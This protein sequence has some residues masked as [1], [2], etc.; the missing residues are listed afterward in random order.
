MRVL[1]WVIRPYL[2]IRYTF[3]RLTKTGGFDSGAVYMTKPF[4][5]SGNLLKDDLHRF[6]VKQF[7]ESSCSVASLAS[8]VNTLMHQQGGVAEPPVSQQDLLDRVKT[9][10]WKERMSDT[11]YKGRRGLPLDILGQVVQSCLDAYQLSY[12]S[13]ETVQVTRS[14][15]QIKACK[16]TLLK[17]LLAFEQQGNC[18]IIAHFDQGSFLPEY[19]IPHISPVGGF[20]P[21]TWAV[22]ILDV[23]STQAHAYQIP[24]NVFYQGLSTD[25][26]LVFRRLGYAE[27]GYVF[28]QL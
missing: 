9:A 25:Y 23:D 10:H 21:E 27:G 20:D 7:H 26:N 3:E 28:I 16:E 8:V 12:Q 2:Y 11:G 24:F 14:P 13:V 1:K 17:R 15:K 5:S 22:K 19:H 4:K 18:L 6:H